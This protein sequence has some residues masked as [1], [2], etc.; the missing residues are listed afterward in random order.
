MGAFDDIPLEGMQFRK[1]DIES[2][3]CKVYF[4]PISSVSGTPELEPMNSGATIK[5]L[6]SFGGDVT[7][8]DGKGWLKMDTLVDTSEPK[9]EGVGPKGQRRS[10]SVFD[11]MIDGDHASVLGAQRL[12]EGVPMLYL[13]EHR[14]GDLFLIGDLC[15]PAYATASSFTGGKGHE[16]TTGCTFTVEA[17]RSLG[18]YTGV[19]TEV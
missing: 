10:K 15:N 3:V 1:P 6:G 11:F 2:G 19:I 14:G 5:E 17:T 8:K 7:F 4:T 9:G 13:V 18:V 12:I 16:D